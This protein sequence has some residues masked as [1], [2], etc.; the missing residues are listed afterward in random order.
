MNIAV[1]LNKNDQMLILF[2]LEQPLQSFIITGDTE[3]LFCSSQETLKEILT[4]ANLRNGKIPLMP[5]IRNS[6]DLGYKIEPDINLD[7][8]RENKV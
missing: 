4:Q 2:K 3:I 7:D 5:Y 1:D 8:D 6:I